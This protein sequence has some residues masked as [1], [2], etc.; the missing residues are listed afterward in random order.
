MT[1]TDRRGLP[2]SNATA[3]C[4]QALDEALDE[5][6]AFRGDPIGRIDAI[7]AA[8]PDFVM[9]HVFRAG[10]LTQEM[11]TRIYRTMVDSVKAAEA[12]WSQANDRERAHICAVRAWI[13][14]DFHSAVQHWETGLVHQPHDLLA[15]A[16][17][18]LTDVLLGDVVGQRD[19]VARVFPMWD[20]SVPGYE[21]VLAF[22]AFGLEENRDFSRG[23][24]AGRRALA[25]R[26][27]HPYAIHAV[28]HV[29][30]MQGRQLGGVHFMTERRDVW[31]N[32]NFR[33]HLWWHL[34]LFLL[35]LGRNDEVMSI[36][37]NNLRGGGVG[38]ER[39]EELDSAAL[40]WRLNLVGIDVGSRWSD[41]ADKWEPSAADTL[42]AF[43]DVHAMMAFA[44][45]GRTEAQARL[46][47][48]NERYLE[49][50]GDANVA[51]SREIGLPFCRALQAFAAKDY[52]TCV[53]QLLPVRYM[54]HR[55]GGSHAQRDIIAW[56]LVEAALRAGDGAL[57]L[58]LANERCQLKPSSPL[59]W[60]LVA[61]AHELKGDRE[62]ARRAWARAESPLAA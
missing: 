55:L 41:L 57:S 36:Y 51:M 46:L 11:E 37:D 21:F 19:C 30:E 10:L 47:T 1:V 12:L 42:Y 5:A 17:V 20:E 27:D 43:N 48:A 4:A 29:M 44:G 31:A 56:T 54:N 58:A 28:A 34:S 35:D 9:G 61:R 40:L 59:N 33:N 16:L 53:D 2:L 62:R 13:E 60:R 18:H 32:G 24:E 3:A 45:D 25:I 49:H 14:G 23:E 38:G 52:R 50:A 22:Y 15:L 26:P 7:L 6:L 8:H 39:Y